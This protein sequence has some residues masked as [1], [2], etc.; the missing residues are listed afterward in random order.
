[1][2]EDKRRFA[3]DTPARTLAEIIDGADVFLGL[4]AGGVLKPE[5]TL[6]MADR[7]IILALAN[8]TPEIL[9]EEARAVRPMPSSPRA[10]RTIRTRSTMCA[11]PTF[12]AGALDSGATTITAEME[13]AAVRAIAELAQAE[14]ATWWRP[15]MWV[16]RCVSVPTT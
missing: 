8:P 2:D 15:L 5:Y 13:V 7:P 16:S 14:Q 3:Q 6:R 1:M 4:S 12:S 11:S 9:P 10:G